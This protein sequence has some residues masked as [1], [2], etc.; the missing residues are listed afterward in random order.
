MKI[1]DSILSAADTVKV[2]SMALDST[3]RLEQ[4]RYQRNDDPVVGLKKKRG[5]S[6]FAEPSDNM[7]VRSIK[8]DST[9][10]FVEI[11]E[12]IGGQQTKVLLRM[13]IEE[14]IELRLA[15][16]ERES[17][18]TLGYAYEL[19]SNVKGLG[20]LIKDIT[21]FEIPLPSVGLLSIFGTPKISLKIGGAVDIH[22]AWRSETTEGVTASRLG[23]TRN[24]PDFKQ[25]VQINVNGTIGDKLNITADWN[26][27][28]TF[29]YENQLK[30][31]YTGYEDEI[32]QSIEAGNVSLQTS[33]LVGGSEAL[34]GIKANFKM[35]PLSLTTIASQKKGEVKEVSVS[36]GSTSAEF[37]IKVT[38]YSKNNYFVDGI[39]ADTSNGRNYFNRYYGNAT[40][41]IDPSVRIVDIEVWKSITTSVIDKTKERNGNAYITLAP[42]SAQSTTQYPDTLRDDFV[43]PIPGLEESARFLLLTRDIDY[44]LHEET[45]YITFL[46]QIQEQDVIAVAYRTPTER[47]G[48]FIATATTDSQRLVLKL[49]KPKSLLPQYT[50]AWQLQL[51]NIYPLNARN[52]KR[53]GFK[54]DIK[55]EQEGSEPVNSINSVPLLTAFGLDLINS[56][57]QA[58]RDDEFDWRPDITIIPVTGEIIFPVLQPF[59]LNMPGSLDTSYRFQ[60]IYEVQ[61]SIARQ[62]KTKDKWVLVG[63]SSGD[64]TSVYQLGFNIVE[65]SVRV[66][67]NGRELSPGIDYSVDYNTGQLTL[68]NSEATLPN[69]DLKI[70]YEQNDLF[71]LAS[72]TLLGARGI[73]DFS[74]KTKLGFSVLNLNQQTLSDKV[75]IGEEPLSNTIYGVDF[76]TAADLPFV[77]KGL[78][79]II[80]TREMSAFTIKGEYAYMNPDPNTKKSTIASDQGK[81]IAYIDDFEGA[82][83]IIPVGVAYT[84]WRDIS[85]PLGINMFNGFSPLEM[86]DYKAK[87]FWFTETPSNVVVSDLYGDR[88]KVATTDQQ[89]TVMDYVFV[90]DTPGTYNYS[91][92]I[93]QK[94]DSTWGGIMKPLSS[95][96]TNLIEE[97]IEFIEFWLQINA[98]PQN[99]QMYIDLGRISE[100]VIPNNKLNYE[101]LDQNGAITTE[102]EDT[103]LD[104]LL[105]DRERAL[106]G[107]TK[108]D[109][110][111]DNF[112]FRGSS[113]VTDIFDYFNINGTQGNAVLTDLGRIPD[114]E[115][116]NR[117]STLDVVNSYFRYAIPLDTVAANNPYIVGGGEKLNGQPS[118]YLYRIPLKDT[119]S[120]F[121]NPDLSTVET[122]R[123]F[124]NGINTPVHIRMTEFNLV[125]SQ[126]QKLIKEDSVLAVSVINR[127]DNPQYTSPPGVFPERD[128]SKPDEEVY[129][130]EQSLNLIITDLEQNDKREA[131]KY[132]FRPLDLFNYTEMKLFIHG[133]V[134]GNSIADT[135]MAG[136]YRAEV[137]F[138]FGGDTNNYYE[139]RQPVKPDWNEISI[140]FSELTTIKQA[141]DSAN[142]VTSIPVEGQPGHF[143]RILG[144]PTLTSIK[145]LTV[146]I[147]NVSDSTDP[148]PISGEV[149][150]NELRVIGADDTPG[151]AYSVSTSFKL[152]DLMTVS[153][154]M[155]HT[156]PYFHK[157]ADR[158]GSRVESRNWSVNTDLNV[159]K[160]LPVNLPESN[161]RI[162]YSHTESVG[163]PLYIPGTDIKVDAAADQLRKNQS[164]TSRS[165]TKTPE[166]LVSE[167]QTINIQDTW[168]ASNIK[169]KIPS[170]HWLVR[171][172]W[173]AI[174]LG[175][176][177]NKSFSR[178]PTTESSKNWV[179]NATVNYGLNLSPTYNFLPVDIPVLGTPF[180]LLTD[181]S[182]LKIYY[183]PQS[184]NLSVT[185]K[186]NRNTNTTR[187]TNIGGSQTTVSRDF[188]TSRTFNFVWKMTEGGFLNLTTNYNLTVNSTLAYL[189]TDAQGQQRGEGDIWKDIFTR[190]FF[191][192]DNQYQQSI[193]FRTAPKLP[194]LWDLNKYF[195][196]TAGYSA[197]Y[198]WSFDTRQQDLGRSAGFTN[199]SNVGLTLRLKSLS[200]PLFAEPKEDLN[201]VPPPKNQTQTQTQTP[202]RRGRDR[203]IG[204][205]Q[206]QTEL[207]N[208]DSLI[209]KDSLLIPSDS[210]A[211]Q[212]SLEIDRTPKVS[213]ITNAL[214]FLKTFARVVLFDYETIS[215]NFTND[216]SLSK[217]GIYGKGTGFSNFWGITYN[218]DNGPTRGFMIGL[219]NDVGRRAANANLNDAFQQ[220]NN[221]DFRTSR[222]LWEGAKIDL[223]WK[224]G[225]SMNKSTT[226]TSDENG[227]VRVNFITA[228]GT[229]N[230]SFLSLPPSL[231]LSVF[232]SGIK[233]VQELYDP[234][235]PNTTENLSNAFIQGFESLPL[236]SKLG[237]LSDVTKYIPR[238]NWRITW[239]GLEKVFIFKSI[240]K[241]VSLDHA[242]QSSYTEGWKI[243]P[244]GVQEVQS[245]KIEYGFTPLVGL[246]I[247]FGELWGGNLTSNIKYS[248][249][250]N[251]DLGIT[252]KNI[253]ETF[254][255]D[256]GIT[257]GY[258]KQGFELPLFGV[259]LKNDIEFS[260]SYT[261]TKNSTVR[262]EMGQNFSEE[263]TPTDGTIRTTIEPRIKYTISSKVTISIFYKRSSVE[264]EGAARIPPTTT[265]EAGLD[266]HIAINN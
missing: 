229:L 42:M 25:Q 48:E 246:N 183:L 51:K 223:T 117:N 225:W 82:K 126:W 39:Y 62:N 148:T 215:I 122:I 224:V 11:T 124:F 216:N 158:F 26:T 102:A 203:D 244:E 49:V 69:A 181:Y 210:L 156:D 213:P 86:M 177:Y 114:T 54:F 93:S 264:P 56:S 33:P 90:P 221:L 67:L 192:Q 46:T 232:N 92:T 104:T 168:S 130:N 186:R 24:E 200:A 88:K 207:K 40:P 111:G 211:V 233:R 255:R 196:V 242:Y 222:P 80:S 141:R 89:I 147:K 248:A 15:L 43:N 170:T 5:N 204:Q 100:D 179:W 37:N 22:G 7:K 27:E 137:Y 10:Q 35:G 153:L 31:K 263:G 29:E 23:N 96:A 176:N 197:G 16:K 180:A 110:S 36:G 75:R 212:D 251:Y 265:N 169:L 152:A 260:L 219:S 193:E 171:D 166:N 138:R 9:G 30:L 184:F 119:S 132:L 201:K 199:R 202:N 34:F 140:L 226:L 8:I 99:T 243:N 66:R 239:D 121:G 230:R 262:Y 235:A 162:N 123:L 32:I 164:D 47:Y 198:Q 95:T 52:L 125:G 38:E 187:A 71:Q 103:G 234:T 167:T 127:E 73:F 68:R 261:S 228:S 17:W 106:Y 45:G 217:S 129:G 78:D 1:V 173:N 58:N 231:F 41:D 113:Q 112:E 139:Y 208:P 136:N 85:P 188:T 175:F 12:K 20:D 133:D 115:D 154:N 145:Y 79:N 174:T 144:N 206:L 120:L 245:Q 76:E 238:P 94:T 163:K 135:T 70:T 21:D 178:N 249:R 159:L 72:K 83:R 64:A 218:E 2:D 131:V 98:A 157:L 240:A 59:G 150:V 256:I 259:A 28:R 84:S 63:K 57:G 128:R 220:K 247:T 55:Y 91:N 134:N 143:Y 3:A 161:L 209:V 116:L 142:V 13:P 160:L 195:S 236:L 149:W 107:S 165:S 50:Q 118:W 254:S 53:D 191:G 250:T 253:T 77:T 155:S 237:F 241:R 74:K 4:F 252:T 101:D 109:P 81:S 87:S 14:Y 172:T 214:N 151:Y 44:K 185:A 6:F 146:G 108:G 227:D 189:E 194:T 18:E 258:S 190:V 60:D 205:N 182:G 19:K 257:A 105:D 61:P 97:N 65:N 266:V